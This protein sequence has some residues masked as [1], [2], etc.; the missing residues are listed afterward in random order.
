MRIKRGEMNFQHTRQYSLGL[1]PSMCCISAQ[2]RFKPANGES[3]RSVSLVHRFR[4][5]AEDQK[6]RK[7]EDDQ[8]VNERR[9]KQMLLYCF[10]NFFVLF[11]YYYYYY[12]TYRKART[13][14]QPRTEP[15][16]EG[17]YQ[18]SR[19]PASETRISHPVIHT[20]T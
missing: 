1:N 4:N 17:I 2:N 8:L 3:N 5:S 10:D 6:V 16:R 13:R 14:P 11:I 18:P 7:E 9:N 12:H 19:C 20:Q 15:S